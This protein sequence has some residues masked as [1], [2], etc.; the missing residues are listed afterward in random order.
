M[1]NEQFAAAVETANLTA[2]TASKMQGNSGRIDFQAGI[3]Y[4]AVLYRVEQ[5]AEKSVYCF[6]FTKWRSQHGAPVCAD[7]MNTLLTS[8]EK[9]FLGID[10]NTQVTTVKNDIKTKRHLF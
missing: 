9:M 10:P 7:A 3:N 4:S 1:F 2:G 6:K 8:V 5:T